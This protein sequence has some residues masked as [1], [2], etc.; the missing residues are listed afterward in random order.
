MAKKYKL[1]PSRAHIWMHCTLSLLDD[2]FVETP[3]TIR[4]TIMHEI[5]EKMILGYDVESLMEK[6]NL[7]DYERFNVTRYADTVIEEADKIPNSDL[8][9]ENKVTL[10]IYENSI[11]MILDALIIGETEATIIDY[12][13]GNFDIE[14]EN[15]YQLFFYAMYVVTAYPHIEKINTIIFQ[16]GRAKKHVLTPKEVIDFFVSKKQVFDDIN[17]DRLSCEPSETVCRF[18]TVPEVK[19]ICAEWIIGG[20]K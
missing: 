3:A 8:F 11:N 17:N 13:S 20:K 12:K 15:N 10:N 19:K 14:V 1:S 7:N 4:G 6:H 16:K 2:T 9:I 18:A 5:G